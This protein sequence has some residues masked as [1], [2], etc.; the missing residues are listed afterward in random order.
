MQPY[1]LVKSERRDLMQNVIEK[2]CHQSII[3]DVFE[4]IEDVLDDFNCLHGMDE[5]KDFYRSSRDSG[6]LDYLDEYC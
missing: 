2:L 6:T 4:S 3:I 1:N 5:V